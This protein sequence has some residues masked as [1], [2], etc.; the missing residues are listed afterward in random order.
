[1]TPLR[2]RWDEVRANLDARKAAWDAAT[3][4]RTRDNRRDEYR[5]AYD[6][7]R[8][9][10]AA[11]TVLD[12]ACGSGNFLYVAL[13]RLSVEK[14]VITYGANQGL[15]LGAPAIRPTQVMGLEINDYAQQLAQV[16]IWIGYL[17]WMLGNGFGYSEPI[18]EALDSIRLQDS[19]LA[20]HDDGSVTEATWP[21][22]QYIVRNPPSSLGGNK[23]RHELG[24]DICDGALC[25]L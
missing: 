8:E 20:F 25:C 15:P 24:D 18:L 13:E 17:Q 16:G 19:L 1:M 11:V 14:D 3:T 7:F 23:I 4:P 22:A 6:A 21:A 10:L 12:P 9:E 5:K 2:R